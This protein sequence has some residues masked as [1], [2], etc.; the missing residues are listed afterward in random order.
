MEKRR[1]LFVMHMPPPVHGSSVVGKNIHDSKIIRDAFECRYVNLMLASTLEDIGGW[2]LKKIVKYKQIVQNVR[3]QL[4]EFRPEVVYVTPTL[5]GVAFFLNYIIVKMIKKRCSKVIIHCH[6]KGV[7]AHENNVVYNYFYKKFFKGLNAIVLTEN[8]YDDIKRY[9]DTKHMFLCANGIPLDETITDDVAFYKDNKRCTFI[10][11]SNMMAEKGV[12]VLLDACKIVAN[13]RMDYVCHFVG[14]W[15]DISEQDFINRCQ[16][17]GLTYST[18]SV[19]NQNAQIIAH[20]PKYGQEKNDMLKRS[21]CFV[22]PTYYSLETLPLSVLEAMQIGL[23]IISTTEGGIP[24]V[25]IDGENGFVCEK[26][27]V[28]SLADAMIKMIKLEEKR[29]DMGNIGR[30][31]YL[32]KYTKTAFE[33]RFRDILVSL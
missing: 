1:V 10:Y 22:F 25:V 23:P 5:R 6:N 9:V 19:I 12:Y 18:P 3:T 28:D 16:E 30:Q 13:K 31:M 14:G 8:L 26:E 17:N 11:L 4:N 32:E 15:T 29:K 24:D 2:G 20:G 7:A 27:D 33:N 21:D